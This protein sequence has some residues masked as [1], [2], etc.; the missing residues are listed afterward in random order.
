[1]RRV[2][3]PQSKGRDYRKML[4]EYFGKFLYGMEVEEKGG[5]VQAQVIY[6]DFKH[7]DTVRRELAQMMPEV[8]FTKLKRDFTQTAQEWIYGRMLS[9]DYKNPPVIYVQRGDTLVKTTII[10]LSRSELCQIE[11][12]DDD[13]HYSPD[14]HDLSCCPK[15]DDER[16]KINSWD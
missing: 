9:P 6:F 2:N 11:L 7:I 13:I 16:L 1:M 15:N 12:D 10:D 3:T 4:K 5:V 14:D 8:E